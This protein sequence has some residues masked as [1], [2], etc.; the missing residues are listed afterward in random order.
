MLT[1]WADESRSRPDLDPNAYLL[2]AALCEEDDVSE[3]RKTMESMRIGEPK[4][5]WHGSSEERRAELVATVAELPVTALVTVHVEPGATDRRHRRKCM[6]Y[7]LPHLA[8]ML[9]VGSS[10]HCGL[11]MLCAAP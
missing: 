1:A 8:S 3:L 7:L 9:W 5:H 4:V 11:P 6:E 2:T 10:R